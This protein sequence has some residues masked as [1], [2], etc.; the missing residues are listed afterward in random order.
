MNLST[1]KILSKEEQ[2]EEVAFIK[3]CSLGGIMG[4]W[5]IDSGI[6]GPTAGITICTHGNEI[7]GLSVLWYFRHHYLPEHKLKKGS[8]LFVLNNIAA[9]EKYLGSQSEREE[10]LARQIDINMNRLPADTMTRQSGSIY[11]IK[12]TQELYPIWQM[13]DA[14]LDLHSFVLEG[15]PIIVSCFAQWPKLIKSWPVEMV[16][17]D[18]EKIQLN[19]PACFFYGHGGKEKMPFIGLECGPHKEKASLITA[20]SCTMSFLQYLGVIED[21]HL[22]EESCK[23][24]V[25][26]IVNS[27]FFPDESYELDHIFGQ[28]EK[29]ENGQI[30]GRNPEGKVVC[31]FCDGLVLFCGNSKKPLSIKEEVLF[32]SAPLG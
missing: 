21:I 28:K 5:H 4:V 22:E 13:F 23:H 2:R 29:I 20:I 32:I 1:I 14:A 26:R 19:K 9:V 16:L 3:R 15:E 17:V 12:R 31:S 24:E 7:S 25:Y 8:I 11:E 6:P 27:I 30:I 18:I 10:L